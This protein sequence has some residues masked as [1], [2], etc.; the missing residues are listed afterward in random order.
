MICFLDFTVTTSARVVERTFPVALGP[1]V[2]TMGLVASAKLGK[3]S[4][5]ASSRR[6]KG[7][8]RN[9]NYT[10]NISPFQATITGR[11]RVWLYESGYSVYTW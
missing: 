10:R 6:H 7:Q 1:V 2:H 8:Q 4:R 11:Q 3:G 9:E 5:E